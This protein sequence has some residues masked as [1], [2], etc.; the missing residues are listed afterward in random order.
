MELIRKPI[1]YTQEG[2][3]IF[4]Q[5]YLDEDYNVPD[6][7][8]DVQRVIQGSAELKAEDIRPVENYV[9]I[10]GKVYFKV[11]YMTASV[12][13]RPSV[14]EG[15]FPFEEMVYAEGDGNET[16]F[17]RNVRTEF[18]ATVVNSRK[19][20]LRIMAEMEVGREWI[21]DEELTEDV[22]S[23]VPVYRKTQK[24]NLLR[25]AISRKDTYRIKEELTLPGTK[26]SIGQ[27]LLTDISV[28]KLDIRMGQDEILLRG[29]LLV[30]CMYLSAEEKA[31]WIEQSVP[32]EG[33]ILCDGVTE[34]MYYHI[35]HS[36]EDTLADIRLDE[37][38]EM[39]VL[40]IE[41]TLSL[42]MNIFG[43]EETE[44]LRDLYS[45][46]QQ[47]IF[48]T[49]DTV[50]EELL[51]QN[52]SKCKI[53]ERLSLPELK[54]DVLQ[55]IHS[56]GSIQV[57]S[58]QHTEEGIR[59]EGILHLSFLYLRGD[60]T[61]PYGNW[62]GMVPFSWTIEYPDM[63][64]KVSSS[65]TSH[66]EQLAVTLAG[67]EAVEVKVVLSF[68]VFLRKL[69]PVEVITNVRMEPFD[70]EMLS[71]RPGI[72]GHIVQNGEDLW[73]LAKKYMTTIEGIKE[74]NGLNDEKVSSGDKLLIFK[75]NVSIL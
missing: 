38:G 23:D 53:S 36:L 56:Q 59:V 72:V 13:P 14:L 20:S 67:S 57:E 75:E 37:D 30:F 11:L 47:C 64:E 43:E 63:P 35:Q 8:E 7:K 73:S 5:F 3:S 45:L 58:E 62:Q 69:T 25:L 33:R 26:E 51:M 22:E 65:L 17:L 27:L 42:R 28:R 31:D 21:R 19:L 60:D 29:E 74:I 40:G 4:D 6:Q 34:N 24:M 66:V 55:I 41:A 2:K 61:E 46:E 16:F 39:R 9:K 15:K 18:T 10:T 52:Q 70:K 54:D 48:E 32:F 1:H 49:K 44:I 68:D 50:L 71:N 12:D